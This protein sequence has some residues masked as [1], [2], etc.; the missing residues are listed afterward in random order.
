MENTDYHNKDKKVEIMTLYE[1]KELIDL[2]GYVTLE[3]DEFNRFVDEMN[4]PIFR[5]KFEA[6]TYIVETLYTFF[7]G[8]TLRT[9][10]KTSKK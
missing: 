5:K 1:I 3:N 8:K 2:N 10:V 6:K 4:L 9:S 7:N